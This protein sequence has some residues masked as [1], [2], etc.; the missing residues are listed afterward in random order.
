MA[1]EDCPDGY[2]YLFR[3]PR[4]LPPDWARCSLVGAQMHLDF[5]RR[6]GPDANGRGAASAKRARAH[7]VDSS[8]NGQLPCYADPA[9]G[10]RLPGPP[11]QAT[12]EQ[13]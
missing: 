6:N 10:T 8:Q 13:A 1:H 12:P 3:Y 7:E 11:S 9:R 2:D 4:L 5:R